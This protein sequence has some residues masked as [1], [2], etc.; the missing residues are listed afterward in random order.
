MINSHTALNFKTYNF[1]T[2]QAKSFYQTSLE[3]SVFQLLIHIMH[4]LPSSRLPL[5]YLNWL[6]APSQTFKSIQHPMTKIKN[7]TFLSY[8]EVRKHL[9]LLLFF[10]NFK[11]LNIFLSILSLSLILSTNHNSNKCFLTSF[12]L[13]KECW[14][15]DFSHSVNILIKVWLGAGHLFVGNQPKINQYNFY[16]VVQLYSARW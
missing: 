16:H 6:I 9:L 2:N 11:I 14:V 15:L 5:D 13:R 4:L 12:S 7:S 10:P 3:G 8:G 1:G